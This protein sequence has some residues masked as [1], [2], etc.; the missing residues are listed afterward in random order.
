[1]KNIAK[2]IERLKLSKA[3]LQKKHLLNTGQ[4]GGF[5]IC[6]ELT[7]ITDGIISDLFMEID[8]G[9]KE[10]ESITANGFALAALGGYGRQELCPKSDIDLL[11]LYKPERLHRKNTEQTGII[12][13]LWDIGFKVGHSTRSTDD[14]IKIAENDLTS[15]TAMMEARFILGNIDL[16]NSF[17]RQFRK[18]TLSAK[19]YQYVRLKQQ[20]TELRHNTF[21]NSIF[22]TEPDLKKS[23][24]TL[25]DYHTALWVAYAQYG[26][27]T[28]SAIN[29]RGL[30]GSSETEEVR[31]AVDFLLKIRCD[32][33][34]QQD[35]PNDV[36]S[37]SMQ[38]KV[39][40]RLG[41]GDDDKES[42]KQMMRDYYRAADVIYRFSNS[43][44]DQA[45]RYRSE[46]SRFSFKP[47]HKKI[48]K[49][50]FAGPEEI[51]LTDITPS[52]LA[53][54]PEKIFLILSHMVR[55]RL[56]PSTGLRKIFLEV[57]RIWKK[58]K[59]EREEISR[60]FRA[61]LKEEDPFSA[62]NVLRDTKILT[63]IIPELRAIRF[64][65]PFDL[66]H[67]FTVDDH[68]FRAISEFDNLKRNELGEC[69]ILRSLYEKENRK[70]LVRA[71]IL[72]HDMG[73]SS[74]DHGEETEIDEASIRNLGYEEDEIGTICKL[75]RHHILMNMVAQRRDLHDD[76]VVTD[77]C[78]K[79]GDTTTLKRLYLLTF[80]DTTAVGPGI[81]NSWKGSLL[82]E[83][84]QK[85]FAVLEKGETVEKPEMV[86]EEFFAK[87][88]RTAAR[89]AAGMP[90]RY[91]LI[92]DPLHAEE[93]AKIFQ[94]YLDSNEST[95]TGYRLISKHEP[96][97]ITIV[98]KNSLGLLQ[99]LVGTL[100][101][102]NFNILDSQ[103]FTRGD[104][105]A[106]DIF[107]ING[108]DEKTVTDEAM[109]N[110]VENEIKNVLS[111]S[112]NVE[113]L[114][115][116]RKKMMTIGDS[117]PSITPEINIMNDVS[118]THTVIE[119]Y[120]RDRLGLLYESTRVLSDQKVDIFS[121]RITTEGHRALNVFYVSEPDGKKIIHSERMDSIKKSL[122]QIL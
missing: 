33:H 91:L 69:S 11:F 27:N 24:G 38:P 81:W 35:V 23:P 89:F 32:L 88:S 120:S 76:K 63:T 14:C 56:K 117:L 36:L 105:I 52:Q 25:R 50:I 94:T 55:K 90:E 84:Y 101:S 82:K 77:F 54:S 100:T 114:L 1:M 51:Y 29:S 83:L 78:E 34:F 107:R 64:L 57:G 39:A 47:S 122:L 103:I 75:V 4:S 121:A 15:K 5:D 31:R 104:G 86:K 43:I 72:F 85:A 26:V 73:K 12:P 108:L 53:F 109:I 20:E 41:Y 28:L 96:G 48:D 2:Y 17:T 13:Y 118:F 59:P 66:Y 111:G 10:Y 74:G 98:T 97:E 115:R 80:A 67:K 106:V 22:L 3:E 71:A 7:S 46:S 16:Y 37:Y 18:K 116:S 113:D 65:T 95:A 60:H 102:K 19:P 44:L 8:G 99:K 40:K 49:N 30:A 21:F 112:I 92:R 79:I 45:R 9:L 119:T 62:L 61:L 93:D 110:R 42:P 58:E 6:Q 70:D 68:T 87:L